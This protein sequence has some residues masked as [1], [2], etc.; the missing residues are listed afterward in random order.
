MHDGTIAQGD[1]WLQSHLGDYVTWAKTRNSLFVLTFDEDDNGAANRIP[2]I[3]AGQR[4][5][6]GTYTETIDRYD[7]LRTLQ[8]AFGLAPLG[9]SAVAEPILDVWNPGDGNLGPHAAFTSS[10]SVLSCTLDT[11]GSTDPP[12]GR[13]GA[14]QYLWDFGD[15]ASGTGASPN[16]PSGQRHLSR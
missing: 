12:D 10:C 1:A 5:T 15:G 16:P 14:A 8:D 4:V 11:S 9:N 6:P 3:M 7:V 2:T 13:R